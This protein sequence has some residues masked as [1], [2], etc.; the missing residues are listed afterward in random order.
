MVILMFCQNASAYIAEVDQRQE[1]F[2]NE[3]ALKMGK[4]LTN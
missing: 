4:N 2:R 3:Y 1:D